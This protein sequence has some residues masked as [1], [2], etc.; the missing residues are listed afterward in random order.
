MGQHEAALAGCSHH[1]LAKIMSA[2]GISRSRGGDWGNGSC[3]GGPGHQRLRCVHSNRLASCVG[4]GQGRCRAGL[5]EE[6]T[7]HKVFFILN[8]FP[9]EYVNRR[10]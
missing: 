8:S 9:I 7:S 6:K 2:V 1:D 10:E 4:V 5:A 3:Q